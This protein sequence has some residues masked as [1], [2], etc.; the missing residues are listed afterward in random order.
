MNLSS[1]DY[2]NVEQHEKTLTRSTFMRESTTT[3]TDMEI[4]DLR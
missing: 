2:G 1:R 4:G 3:T